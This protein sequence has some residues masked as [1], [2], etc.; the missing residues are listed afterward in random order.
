MS[1]AADRVVGPLEEVGVAAAPGAGALLPG[2][3][4]PAGPEPLTAAGSPLGAGSLRSAETLP[5][6]ESTT[7]AGPS[8]SAGPPLA[9][10]PHLGAAPMPAAGLRLGS[11]PLP[12]AGPPFGVASLRNSN[13]R[14]DN[15]SA[16][17]DLGSALRS[18]HLRWWSW[19][20]RGSKAGGLRLGIGVVA[21]LASAQVHQHADPGVICPLRRLTGVPCPFCG[22]TTVFMEAGAGHWNAALAANP[23]T[24]VAA[25]GFLLYPVLAFDGV[26][27]WKRLP[28]RTQWIVGAVVLAA[29]WVWQLNRFNLL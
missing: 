27:R 15:T 18:P 23:V 5:R 21:A 17:F 2:D 6:A 8:L 4:S 16:A 11:E 25:L 26:E 20:G 24:V 12:A 1:G 28:R 19:S 29:S 7:A 13:S 14:S 3:G 22:S 9:V 10:G